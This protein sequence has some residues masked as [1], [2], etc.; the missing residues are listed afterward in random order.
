MNA[1]SEHTQPADISILS[2]F[3]SPEDFFMVKPD[4]PALED[5]ILGT[6]LQRIGC[7]LES[8]RREFEEDQKLIGSVL[9]ETAQYLVDQVIDLVSHDEFTR[10]AARKS[11]ASAQAKGV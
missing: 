10:A 11:Q 2:E 7:L 8:A 6:H 1:H 3:S 9:L 4:A 5:G